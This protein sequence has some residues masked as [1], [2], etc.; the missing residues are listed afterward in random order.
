MD[1][2]IQPI[3]N[4]MIVMFGILTIFPF[5]AMF[6]S[7]DKENAFNATCRSAQIVLLACI[8]LL[9]SGCANIDPW[10]KRDTLGQIAATI[11]IAGDGV[12]S[13][14]IRETENV[15]EHGA[16]A[17]RIMG[18][19][20]TKEDLLLY[21]TTL[22]VSSYFIARALPAS[23]RPYFQTIEVGIHGYA[24]YNNCQLELC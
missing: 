6:A 14:K 2:F 21:H 8:V 18:P 24:W 3:A 9:L 12:S 15:S 20:P 4:I 17:R 10:T 19:Q 1:E 5:I 22:A 23:W 7:D 11:A 13:I 16:I